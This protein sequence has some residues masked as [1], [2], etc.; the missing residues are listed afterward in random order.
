VSIVTL[1]GMKGPHVDPRR[2]AMSVPSGPVALI[3]PKQLPTIREAPLSERIA[4][5]GSETL[6]L[7]G[8]VARLL[9]Q[10]Y[11]DVANAP[12]R[13]GFLHWLSSGRFQP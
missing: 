4:Q 8:S 11:L 2:Q 10:H 13:D 12:T 7:N 3:D 1:G 6:G 9:A 5:A